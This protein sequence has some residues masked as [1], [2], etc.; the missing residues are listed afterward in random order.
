MEIKIE[1]NGD[2]QRLQL[3]GEL[4]A[5]ACADFREIVMEVAVKQP[6]EII[7]DMAGVP[8]ID[9]SGLGVLVGLRTHMKSKGIV[10]R[11]VN[12]SEK[13]HQNF[14]LT[15]LDAIFGLEEK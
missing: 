10:L 11:L 15:R 5:E 13:V 2:Q 9:T 7:L 14:K 6:P 3:S 12:P 8:F 1:G 4:V